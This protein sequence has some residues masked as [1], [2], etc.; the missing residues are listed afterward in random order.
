MH[1]SC[2]REA[3]EQWEA[4]ERKLPINQHFRFDVCCDIAFGAELVASAALFVAVLLCTLIFLVA[5]SSS[6]SVTD[7]LHNLGSSP[8]SE[9]LCEDDSD[10]GGTAHCVKAN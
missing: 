4:P 8:S 5:G 2:P 10:H 6:G 9:G 7:E 1:L 3:F